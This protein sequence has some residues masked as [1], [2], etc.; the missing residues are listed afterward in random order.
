MF[1]FWI[2]LGSGK[3]VY[4][5]LSIALL[6]VYLA[7]MG[8]VAGVKRRKDGAMYWLTKTQKLIRRSGIASMFVGGILTI[9][10]SY[11]GAEIEFYLGL[12]LIALGAALMLLT[13]FSRAKTERWRDQMFAEQ[14]VRR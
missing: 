3:I 7:A 1:F 8:A 13:M 14:R 4:E 9:Y 6:L 12:G 2:S 11:G 5:N 10:G